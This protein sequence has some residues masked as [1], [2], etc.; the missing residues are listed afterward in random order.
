MFAVLAIHKS[1]SPNWGKNLESQS[2]TEGIPNLCLLQSYSMQCG[3]GNNGPA[4]NIIV[5][6][7]ALKGNH[8]LDGVSFGIIPFLIPYLAHQQ[9]YAHPIHAVARPKQFRA[10]RPPPPGGARWRP[11]ATASAG[12]SHAAPRP[13]ARKAMF[14]V[15]KV[16]LSA[17]LVE[18]LGGTLQLLLRPGKNESILLCPK[19]SDFLTLLTQPTPVYY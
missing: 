17:G 14:G 4:H 2:G 15:R 3:Q 7:C 12:D 1:Q 18:A 11:D 8:Q 19:R 6:N 16:R 5:E 9:E 13:C 10:A